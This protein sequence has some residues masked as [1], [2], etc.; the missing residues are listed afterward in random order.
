MS[1]KPISIKLKNGDQATIREIELSDAKALL[2]MIQ[3]AVRTS[4]YLLS[5]PEEVDFTIEEETAWIKATKSTKGTFLLVAEIGD[6]IIGDME[7]RAGSYK[8]TAHI[9]TL[10]IAIIDEYRSVGL[11]SAFFHVMLDNIR[12]NTDLEILRLSVFSKNKPAIALYKKFGFQIEGTLK[13]SFKLE[14]DRYED[15]ILMTLKIKQ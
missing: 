13:N 14:E 2:E 6:K 12:Q 15:E 10:G 1:L 7:V 5:S 11:G 8:K 9:G 4:D 3:S